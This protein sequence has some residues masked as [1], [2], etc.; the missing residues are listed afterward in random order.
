MRRVDQGHARNLVGIPGGI[1]LCVQAAVGMAYQHV[2]ALSVGVGEQ[3][4][5]FGG[6]LFGVSGLRASFAPAQAGTVIDAHARGLGELLLHPD[7]AP[8][9]PGWQ[10]PGSPWAAFS[11]A[12]DV[13]AVATHVHHL[14]GRGIAALVYLGGYG[15]V[16]RP[17]NGE[18]EE[19]GDR[20]RSPRWIQDPSPLP[21]LYSL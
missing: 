7:S 21:W 16:D 11:E 1:H 3:G 10:L 14:A 13:Q 20:P 5:Q 9:C 2:G 8:T 12:V 17:E 4:V 18:C 6:D 19:P 15:L